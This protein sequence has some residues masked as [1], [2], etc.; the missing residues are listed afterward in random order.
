MTLRT[1]GSSLLLDGGSLANAA[2]CCCNPD[3]G[4]CECDNGGTTEAKPD[5]TFTI[6]GSLGTAYSLLHYPRFG[7]TH[8]CPAGTK[9]TGITG[10]Y[11]LSCGEI[12][13]EYFHG[14]LCNTGTGADERDYYYTIRMIIIYRPNADDTKANALQV[15][16]LSGAH[17]V[18][19]SASTEDRIDIALGGQGQS[20]FVWD[21]TV[22]AGTCSTTGTASF[23]GGV[24]GFN[25]HV[26]VSS[27]LTVS[28]S[29]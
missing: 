8:T 21:N 22:T 18:A 3:P 17:S 15:Q 11:V 2:A 27:G 10:D 20:Y 4:Y 26:D 14:F 9:P 25:N 24:S 1:Y 19:P 5:L 6:G 23:S 16:L 12:Y 28:V 7:V 29:A 13:T